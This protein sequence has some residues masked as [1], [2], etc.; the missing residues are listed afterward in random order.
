MGDCPLYS[1]G[2]GSMDP[3]MVEKWVI[4]LGGSTFVGTKSP[5]GEACLYPQEK[6][7]ISSPRIF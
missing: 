7:T 6:T 5:K 3:L 1:K 2:G 4:P